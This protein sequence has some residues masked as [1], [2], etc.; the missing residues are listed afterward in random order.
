MNVEEFLNDLADGGFRDEISDN[1]IDSEQLMELITDY[2]VDS[3]LGFY[4]GKR[5]HKAVLQIS[6]ITRLLHRL[7]ARVEEDRV[8]TLGEPL[9][10]A[11]RYAENGVRQGDF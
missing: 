9:T 3:Y 4:E 1:I 8:Q 7:V 2:A 5:S 10:L 6:K 11:E